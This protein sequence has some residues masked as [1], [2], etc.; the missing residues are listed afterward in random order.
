MSFELLRSQLSQA[1]NL[2]KPPMQIL[3]ELAKTIGDLSGEPDFFHYIREQILAV[4]GLALHDS[5]TLDDELANIQ[6]RIDKMTIAYHNPDFSDEQRAR[7]AFALDSHNKEFDRLLL[8]KKH[9]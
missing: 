1:I 4:Y 8:L 9:S 7:I 6:A 3:L 5:F 2:G